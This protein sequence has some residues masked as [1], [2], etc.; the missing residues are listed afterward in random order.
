MTHY[1][2]IMT[3]LTSVVN[4]LRSHKDNHTQLV[5]LI[6]DQSKVR[7][8][9]HNENVTSRTDAT[10]RKWEEWNRNHW[11]NGTEPPIL[12][13]LDNVNSLL[14]DD[15]SWTCF[16]LNKNQWSSIY[17]IVIFFLQPLTVLILSPVSV[18]KSS[19]GLSLNTTDMTENF[20]RL[21]KSL[22]EQLKIISCN[23]YISLCI[24]SVLVQHGQIAAQ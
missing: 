5:A 19:I 20:K 1:C 4:I 12:F 18:S 7:S 10:A 11:H 13:L 6:F 9:G 22:P 23:P 8:I 21:V 3:S 17:S 15:I 16:L 14:L 2:L 24:V